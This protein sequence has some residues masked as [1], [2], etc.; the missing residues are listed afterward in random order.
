MRQFP[1]AQFKDFPKEFAT[2]KKLSTPQ[3]IQDFLDGIKIN[4][5]PKGDTCHS[6]LVVLQTRRAHCIE[7][8]MLAAAALWVHGYPPLLLD[9]K[10][11]NNDQDHVVTLFK[12]G[13]Y[14]GAISKTNHAVLR[15]RDPI[16]KTPRELAMSYFHEYF[17]NK[18]GKKTLRSY[19][20]T[21]FDLSK[22]DTNWLTSRE[23]LWDVAVA[24][25]VALH[26]AILPKNMQRHLR[27]ARPIER[28]AGKIVEWRKERKNIRHR[29]E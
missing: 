8:A 29:E 24:L 9:L 4:F 6:P 23:N 27:P 11:I 10:T 7:G 2:L 13:N 26:T 20:R 16:Y 25:D 18:N 28:Q 5:E 19:S 14:W 15:Y 12:K 21:P 1:A 22:Q 17:L 3:K